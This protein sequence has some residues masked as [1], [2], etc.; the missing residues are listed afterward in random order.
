MRKGVRMN[1][2]FIEVAGNT[3]ETK[4]EAVP[5]VGDELILSSDLLTPAAQSY[6]TNPLFAALAPEI[7]PLVSALEYYTGRVYL[8]TGR[9]WR[10]E[11]KDTQCHLSLKGLKR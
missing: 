3:L 6:L 1:K 9:T 4:L 10:Y 2:V 8:V 11:K 5:Q 7:P